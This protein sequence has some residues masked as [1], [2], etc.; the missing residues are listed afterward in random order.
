ML[1]MGTDMGSHSVT[2]HPTQVNTPCLN[3]SQTGLV[4]MWDLLSC[5]QHRIWPTVGVLVVGFMRLSTVHG[6]I[7]RCRKFHRR[8]SGRVICH[9]LWVRRWEWIVASPVRWTARWL[10]HKE[11]R[12]WYWVFCGVNLT[13]WDDD[14]CGSRDVFLRSWSCCRDW[15][16]QC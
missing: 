12:P 6:Q 9:R 10:L 4:I 13:S 15:K 11:D 3:P 5:S 1:T 8:V 7:S 14:D 2:C 16:L